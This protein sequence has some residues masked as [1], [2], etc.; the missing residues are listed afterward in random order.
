V[1][2]AVAVISGVL[3]SAAVA[4]ISG[5]LA[6]AA[7]GDDDDEDGGGGD[8]EDSDEDGDEDGD[9]GGDEEDSGAVW[10]MM[11]LVW[12]MWVLVS[13][14]IAALMMVMMLA[15]TLQGNSKQRFGQL[16]NRW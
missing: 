15:A 16:L 6:S 2:A 3:A 13:G 1:T 14:W 8:D 7:G 10:L 12:G 11:G 4:V 9:E 5:M